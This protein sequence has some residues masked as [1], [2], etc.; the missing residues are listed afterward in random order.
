MTVVTVPEV[1][2]AEQAKQ[3][4]TQV[5]NLN[6][7]IGPPSPKNPKNPNEF[8]D[9]VL[10]AGG[11]IVAD[12]FSEAKKTDS[13]D[14][15]AAPVIADNFSI[16]QTTSAGLINIFKFA[17]LPAIESKLGGGGGQVPEVKPGILRRVTQNIKTFELPGGVP[18]FQV[19][20]VSATMF[21]IVGLFM[22]AEEVLANNAKVYESNSKGSINAYR[23]EARLDAE[24]YACYFESEFVQKGMPVEIIINSRSNTDVG[25]ALS[26]KALLQNYRYFIV[27]S[28]RVYYAMDALILDY[29]KKPTRG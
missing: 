9:Q 15:Q 25:I 16:V 11:S 26:Y 5:L 7:L 8:V 29:F 19:L 23:P 2:L 6:G 24:Y 4:V 1:T 28:D 17:L 22:G 10:S 3:V 21:Q 27:R 12:L 14:K 18:A 13:K 20:G